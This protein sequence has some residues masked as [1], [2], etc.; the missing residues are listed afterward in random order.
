MHAMKETAQGK[1]LTRCGLTV[2]SSEA[3]AWES[4][5]TCGK[6]GIKALPQFARTRK[7][8]KLSAVTETQQTN[9]R[10]KEMA[11][12]AGATLSLDQDF[13]EQVVKLRDT[14]EKKWAEIAEITEVAAG[15]C[16]LAYASAHVPKKEIIKNATAKDVVA[17]RRD[18]SLSWGE[19]S[20]RVLLPESTCRGMYEEATGESTKGLR[21]GKGGRHPNEDAPVKRSAKDKATAKGSKAKP[22]TKGADL[23][24]DMEPTDIKAAMTGYAIKVTD[25]NGGT[26]K[27]AVKQVKKVANGK[28]LIVDADTGESRTI[29]LAAVTQISKRKVV[30]A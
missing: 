2:K 14:D 16:M 28:A 7:A 13:V 5:V 6:C 29:K 12:R 30:A 21:I 26:E 15:K 19:I 23:F 24:A 17:L 3:T 20:V 9:E 25:G 27:F 11:P 8:D 10:N 22:E 4:E 18:R 1:A